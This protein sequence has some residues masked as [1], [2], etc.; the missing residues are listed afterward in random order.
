M[1][2]KNVLVTVWQVGTERSQDRIA[3]GAALVNNI[4]TRLQDLRNLIKDAEKNWLSF[5]NVFSDFNYQFDYHL[6]VA[7]EY[8]F[9][10][11]GTRPFLSESQKE[12]I[13]AAISEYAQSNNKLI[14]IPGTTLWAKSTARPGTRQAKR[15]TTQQKSGGAQRNLSK[16]VNVYRENY[17][18]YN[19]NFTKGSKDPAFESIG[20][21]RQ[22]RQNEFGERLENNDDTLSIVRNTAFMAWGTTIHKCHKRYE[23]VDYET[24]RILEVD[25]QV[26]WSNMMFMPGFQEDPYTTIHGMDVAVE[27]CAEHALGFLKSHNMGNN[28]FHVIVSA[29]VDFDKQMA[30]AKNGGY[31]VHADSRE[32]DVYF[33]D[34]GTIKK[35]HPLMVFGTIGGKAKCYMCPIDV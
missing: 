18:E 25:N 6:F 12:I 2:I 26:D 35:S 16:Y 10:K 34:G 24:R 20:L 32:A 15:G 21:S 28:H 7:P 29:S 1:S 13:R 11:S 30:Q 5:Q 3:D 8:L 27:I 22:H 31:V 9:A 19:S 17:E 4:T 14:L 33:N 23:N